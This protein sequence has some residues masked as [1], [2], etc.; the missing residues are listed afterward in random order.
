MI[1][2]ARTRAVR[3]VHPR[4]HSPPIEDRLEHHSSALASPRRER[5][6]ESMQ[7][8]KASPLAPHIEDS[9]REPPRA[10]SGGA[11]HPPAI[12]AASAT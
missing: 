3:V 10:T 8:V 5:V 11:N 4:T 9:Q 12:R 1:T 2:H 7:V 6:A